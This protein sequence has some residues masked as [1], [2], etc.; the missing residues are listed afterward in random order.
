M[1]ILVSTVLMDDVVE[2]PPLASHEVEQLV[3]CWLPS[4]AEERLQSV[5]DALQRAEGKAMRLSVATGAGVPS[6]AHNRT[7]LVL[8]RGQ[9]ASSASP[10]R[11]SRFMS[12]CSNTNR[13]LATGFLD[14]GSGVLRA[15]AA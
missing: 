4:G 11:A 8:I 1:W 14:T 12:K 15:R 10:K 7:H 3:V 13:Q 5:A 2:L 6:Y 9:K